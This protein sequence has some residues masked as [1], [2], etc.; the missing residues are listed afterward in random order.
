MVVNL[1]AHPKTE[2]VVTAI[3]KIRETANI[4]ARV[5]HFCFPALDLLDAENNLRSVPLRREVKN[6]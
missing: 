2:Y 3:F 4:F 1:A 6:G 5:R